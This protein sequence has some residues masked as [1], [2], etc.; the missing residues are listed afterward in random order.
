[1]FHCIYVIDN[2]I[3]I[4]LKNTCL[5]SKVMNILKYLFP[6]PKPDSRRVMTFANEEDYISFRYRNCNLTH[7]CHVIYV[8]VHSCHVVHVHVHARHV[9]HVHVHACKCTR[10]S[11]CTCRRTLMSCRTCTCTCMSRR[12]CTR[13]CTSRRTCTRACTSRRTCTHTCTSHHTYVYMYIT[14][15]ICTCHNMHL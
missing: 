7:A 1:M 14:F 2:N 9:T 8:H 5:F 10:T 6:V 11:R 3:I 15:Y 4:V 13:T 12:T